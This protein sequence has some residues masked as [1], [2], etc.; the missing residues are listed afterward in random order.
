VTWFKPKS[1]GY[2]ASPAGWK[3]WAATIAFLVLDL[4][5]TWVLIFAP[6]LDTGTVSV[7]RI[8]IWVAATVA[9]TIG[10]VLVARVKTDGEW[11]WRWGT[12]K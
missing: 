12:D 11:R 4:A 7:A 1:H 5:L 3:G 6:L 8:V 9:L 10:F 2:G